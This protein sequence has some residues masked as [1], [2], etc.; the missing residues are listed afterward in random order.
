MMKISFFTTCAAFA[1]GCTSVHANVWQP[2]QG[3]TQIPIWPAT[4]PDAHFAAG[5][6][7]SRTVKDRLIAG[8]PWTSA[9][10]VSQPTMTVYSPKGTNAGVPFSGPYGDE[11]CQL[12]PGSE[13]HIT[14]QT[15][16]TFLLQNE[17]DDVDRVADSLSYYA[18]LKKARVP[19]EMHLYAQGGHAFRLRRTKFPVTAWPQRVETWLRTIGMVTE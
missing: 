10:K 1:L 3:H 12:N 4:I 7:D 11:K 19:V 5:K 16:P 14:R 2:S 8:K 15:A 6:Q 9:E 13:S 17:N 18:A